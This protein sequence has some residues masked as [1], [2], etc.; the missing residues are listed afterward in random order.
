MNNLYKTMLLTVLMMVCGALSAQILSYDFEQCNVGDKVAETLGEP[1]TT[2]DYSPGSATDALITDEQSLGNRAV[3]IDNGNDLVLFLGDKT[4]GAYNIS[5]DMYIPNG[6]EGYFNILH[7]FAGSNSVWAQQMWLNSAQHGNYFYPGGAYDN[8]EVPFDEWIHI[9]IDI[10]LDDAT[11]CLKLNDELII[12]W[13]YTLSYPAKYCSISAMDFCPSNQNDESKNGFFVDNIT[14]TELVGPFISNIVPEEASLEVL[15]LKDEQLDVTTSFTNEGNAICGYKAPWIDYGVGPD[16]GEPRTLHYDGDPYWSFGNYNNDPYTEIGVDFSFQQLVDSLLVGTKITSMQYFVPWDASWGCQG[17]LKFS[18]YRR[19]W[20]LNTYYYT[21]LAEKELSDYTVADWNTVVFDEP[22]PITGCDVLATVG[23]QQIN[24]GYPISLD[25]G[26]A[27]QYH[28]DLVR[29]NGGSWFSLN[30]EYIYYNGGEGYGNHNIRLVCE[31]LPV[32]TEWISGN[33]SDSYL[34]MVF[35]PGQTNTV[36]FSLNSDGLEHGD[37]YATFR[38]D[39]AKETDPEVALPI[40]LRV[41]GYDVK[42][43]ADGDS[44]FYPNPASDIVYVEGNDWRYAIIFNTLGEQVGIKKIDSNAIHVNDLKD[45]VY[46]VCLMNGKGEKL[47]Q[48]LVISK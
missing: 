44:R 19:L 18:V 16:G 10:F 21:L 3:K 12:A 5:F 28:G 11:A 38:L 42:E 41:S 26:P 48:R 39:R 14:F 24:G 35:A 36:E 7:Q 30:A 23:F 46:Q 13:N 1:W 43:Y 17:P 2:W 47:V 32:E 20:N 40:H 6:K 27:L 9:D 34:A 25:E 15:M 29:L 45:G 31:G 37:Y 4:T 8:F 33:Y 22:I